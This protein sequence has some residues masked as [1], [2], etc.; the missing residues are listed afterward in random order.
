[1]I[2]Y[3]SAIAPLDDD[4]YQGGELSPEGE[5]AGGP[6][7]S[8][9]ESGGGEEGERRWEGRLRSRLEKEEMER[10]RER[11]GNF[12]PA[13]LGNLKPPLTTPQEPGRDHG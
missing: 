5:E 7:G 8:G 3:R 1:M 12:K 2:L 11:V 13:K 6:G 4:E 10:E 9:S